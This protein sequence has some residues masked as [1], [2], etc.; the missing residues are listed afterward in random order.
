MAAQRLAE[1]QTAVAVQ[2]ALGRMTEQQALQAAL[3]R[4]GTGKRLELALYLFPFIQG[5]QQQTGM[6]DVDGTDQ[7]AVAFVAQPGSIFGRNRQPPLVVEADG[8][9][10]T[11]QIAVPER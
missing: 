10:A 8:V 9:S 6:G 1:Q 4:V 11:Q 2:L 7:L 3:R 5:I